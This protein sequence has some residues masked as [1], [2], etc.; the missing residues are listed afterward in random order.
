MCA[1]NSFALLFQCSIAQEFESQSSVLKEWV[2]V[3]HKFHRFVLFICLP[4]KSGEKGVKCVMKISN[5]R[6]EK[7][8][9]CVNVNR[10]PSPIPMCLLRW[11]GSYINK[12]VCSSH[13]RDPVPLMRCKFLIWINGNEE[14]ECAQNYGI[15]YTMFGCYFLGRVAIAVAIAVVNLVRVLVE[16]WI[17]FAFQFSVQN[18]T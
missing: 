17:A 13:F 9:S 1:H 11:Y 6:E 10:H 3:R 12:H 4:T 15:I 7:K 2:F 18:A 16:I 14:F 5:G 8:W